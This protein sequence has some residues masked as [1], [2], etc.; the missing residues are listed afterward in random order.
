M[1]E[2]LGDAWLNSGF[3]SYLFAGNLDTRHADSFDF[4]DAVLMASVSGLPSDV[5]TARR[6]IGFVRWTRDAGHADGR[7]TQDLVVIP[8]GTGVFQWYRR[9]YGP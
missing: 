7:G 9:T 1:K 4:V 5:I 6:A 2:E 3:T 8:N